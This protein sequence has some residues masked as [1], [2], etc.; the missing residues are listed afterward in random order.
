[1]TLEEC[2][3][4]YLRLA[5]KIFSPKR[6]TMN[7]LRVPDYFQ[8]NGK[9]DHKVLEDAVRSELKRL[10]ER[11]KALAV[12]GQQTG[13]QTPQT[14][15]QTAGSGSMS[16]GR[17]NTQPQEAKKSKTGLGRWFKQKGESAELQAQKLEDGEEN[18]LLWKPDSRCKV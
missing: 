15:P 18:I 9:F 7:P 14:G 13:Q 1:M 11:R 16:S 12:Y 10:A 4:A 6:S 17:N 5:E 2:E 8:A 3:D